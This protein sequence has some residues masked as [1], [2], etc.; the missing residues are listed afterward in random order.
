MVKTKF[1]CIV[2]PRKISFIEKDLEI[3][4]E[5]VLI[6]VYK[7]F[8]CGSEL[9][10][11]RGEYPEYVSLP[12]C[13]GHEGAGEIVEVGKKV[14]K[15]NVG[16]KVIVYS[17][18]LIGPS[19]ADPLFSK[20]ARAYV[21]CLQL[22][23]SGISL[24]IAGLAEPLSADIY[25]IYNCD[26]KLGDS[27]AII[28][29]GFHGQVIIQGLKRSGIKTIIGIDIVESKLKLAESRGA[30][31]TINSKKEDPIRIVNEITNG[32]GVDVAIEAVG[33]GETI[34]LAA[35]L[36]RKQGKL[37]L[38]GWVTRPT[39][40]DLCTWHIKSLQIIML[41][42]PTFREKIFWAEKG[43]ELIKKGIIEINSL[44]S[45]EYP[46]EKLNEAFDRYDKDPNI[47]KLAIKP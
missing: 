17:D 44:I 21:E 33:K 31:Y 19:L 24:D 6:K 35:S 28:G 13:I 40:I 11:Y 10:Y 42:P 7:A 1:G 4:D 16:D 8:L 23:P 34:N 3:N 15:F 26:A 45:G 41:K 43:F 9:H 18:V 5:Q 29:L 14:S 20:Y 32:K 46:L 47:I 38:F 37:G 22:V 30:D 2:A 39:S 27:C 25:T 12:K 36:L